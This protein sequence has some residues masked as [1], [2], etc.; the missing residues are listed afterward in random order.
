MISTG[1]ILIALSAALLHATWNA[2]VKGATDRA[3]SIGLVS[4]GHFVPALP[5]FF[6]LPAPDMAALPYIIASTVIHWGYYF[7]LIAAYKH[8]DLSVAYPIA[9]GAAPVLIALGATIW[10]G[11]ILSLMAWGGIIGVSCGVTILVVSR[12]TGAVKKALFPAFITALMVAAYSIVDGIGVRVS[13]APLSYITWLFA[14]EICVTLFVLM[15]RR[16]LIRQNGMKQFLTGFSGGVLSS[17]SYALAVFAQSLA[18]LALVAA[19][20]ETSV[21]LAAL[22]GVVWFKE[23]PVLIRIFAAC[24]V[25]FGVILIALS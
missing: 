5:F 22:I 15:P 17:L 24:V 19:I 9:R 6:I 11:E 13:G 16:A 7:F 8:S 4:L 14:A 21:I 23:R 10:P 2:M 20:R 25:A 1:V 18:P 3:L 12:A